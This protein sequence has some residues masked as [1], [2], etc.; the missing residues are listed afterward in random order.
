MD[1]DVC[2]V[3]R[4]RNLEQQFGITQFFPIQAQVIP[5]ILRSV[6]CGGCERL[7]LSLSHTHTLSLTHA[8]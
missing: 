2:L 1:R 4:L 3:D 7:S 5:V 6:A 8:H